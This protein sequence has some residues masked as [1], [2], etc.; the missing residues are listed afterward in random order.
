M[1]SIKQKLI[2]YFSTFMALFF[3]LLCVVNYVSVSNL[4]M[5]SSEAQLVTRAKDTSRLVDS[6]VD[7]QIREMATLAAVMDTSDP[8]APEKLK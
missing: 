8:A 1:K 6:F 4:L 3:V 2:L 7:A 5:D